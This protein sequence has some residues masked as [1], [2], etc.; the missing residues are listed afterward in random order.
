MNKQNQKE[1]YGQM[2]NSETV[3]SQ[4]DLAQHHTLKNGT[5]GM[6]RHQSHKG[7]APYRFA[8]NKLQR[9]IEAHQNESKVCRDCLP[10]SFVSFENQLAIHISGCLQSD[11]DKISDI[12]QIQSLL[13]EYKVVR[14]LEGSPQRLTVSL[15]AVYLILQDNYKDSSFKQFFDVFLGEYGDVISKVVTID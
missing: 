11:G 1:L 14:F 3:T 9:I 15:D 12:S 7:L 2:A 8:N 4:L 5:C 13:S 10:T 6:N